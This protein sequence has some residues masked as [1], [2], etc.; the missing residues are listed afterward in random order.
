M[1]KYSAEDCNNFSCINKVRVG[2][3]HIFLICTTPDCIERDNC[4]RER[5]EPRPYNRFEKIKEQ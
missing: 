1:A 5:V 3:Q 2:V 4:D